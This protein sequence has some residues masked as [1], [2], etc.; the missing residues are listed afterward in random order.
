MTLTAEGTIVDVKK[1]KVQLHE[2]LF[3]E[4]VSS[5]WQTDRK[6]LILERLKVVMLFVLL[7]CSLRSVP[8]NQ[9]F[10]SFL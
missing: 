1:R 6:M 5:S 10:G 9:Y 7:N 8:C 4:N 2:K 3:F